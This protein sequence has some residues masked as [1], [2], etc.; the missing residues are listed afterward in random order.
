MRP[1]PFHKFC[2]QYLIDNSECME[3][4]AHPR[5]SPF[6]RHV[7]LIRTFCSSLCAKLFVSRSHVTLFIPTVLY[8]CF[9]FSVGFGQCDYTKSIAM[10]LVSIA[11]VEAVGFPPSLWGQSSGT[12]SRCIPATPHL[13]SS[14]SGRDQFAQNFHAQSSEQ[15]AI[16]AVNSDETVCNWT[17]HVDSQGGKRKK[18]LD[19][20]DRI[21]KK[22]GSKEK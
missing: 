8:L 16:R 1:Q 6:E 22:S 20:G 18:N 7:V 11:L 9:L 12:L 15:S 21:L 13:R 2:G 5:G 3:A 17:P 4:I 14:H 19:S 10:A